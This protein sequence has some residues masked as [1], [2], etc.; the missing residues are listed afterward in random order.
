MS[1]ESV[2]SYLK[3]GGM[4]M[5]LTEKIK[6]KALDLGYTKVGICP[7]N[8]FPDYLQ[9]LE[10]RPVTYDFY[11]NRETDPLLGATPKIAAPEAKSI[12]S[13]AYGFAHIDYPEKLLGKIGR[14]YMAR[15]YKPKEGMINGARYRIFA[16]FLKENGCKILENVRIPERATA[17]RAGIA[18]FGKNNFAYIEEAGS[19][20]VLT[21]FLVDTEL[22][23]DKPTVKCPCPPNCHICIDS[24]PTGAIIQPGEL[25]PRKCI[26]F[27]NWFTQEGYAYN[28][29]THIPHDI[30][31]KMG[32]H[33]H[34]CDVC[35]EVCPRNKKVLSDVCFKDN[36]LERIAEE[37]DLAKVLN[38]D[39][40]YYEE[41]IMPIMYNY[42]KGIRYFRRNAA[43]AIGNIGEEQYI[44]DLVIAAKDSDA[45]VREY[46]IWA[47]G[48]IGGEKS[49][50]ILKEYLKAE[51]D[52]KVRDE[53]K[54]SIA[55]INAH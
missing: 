42:I 37:F 24:C 28:V 39:E 7:A 35:Q 23:Y 41:V 54:L 32:V 10:G 29:T 20:V 3:K 1:A 51:K 11:L 48:K 36:F 17:A 49:E 47:L 31:E 18:T 6:A 43:I 22:D 27:N 45:L 30:R 44:D 25:D 26:S 12:I 16:A 38:M 4:K 5:N 52:A 14:A 50:V 53:I 9:T 55:R 15:C 2:I 19:F 13:L 8:D 46:A 40:E 33:I 34:G 21:S